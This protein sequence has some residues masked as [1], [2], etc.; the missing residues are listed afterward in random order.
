MWCVLLRRYKSNINRKTKLLT[1]KKTKRMWMGGINEVQDCDNDKFAKNNSWAYWST[2]GS[3]MF[4]P[5]NETQY[6]S[7]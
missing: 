4:L 1:N 2:Y 3:C 7:L 6:T 5:F